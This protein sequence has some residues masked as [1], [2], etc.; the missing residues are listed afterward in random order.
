MGFRSTT[1][2]LRNLFLQG[3]ALL[4]PLIITIALVVWLGRSVEL[5]MGGVLRGLMPDDWYLPGMGLMAGIGVTLAAGLL[6]KARPRRSSPCRLD[7]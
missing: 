2:N 7:S 4:A 5:W 6:A 1:A 3:I